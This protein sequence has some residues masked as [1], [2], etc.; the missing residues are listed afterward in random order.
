MSP[1]GL[2]PI[3]PDPHLSSQMLH[4]A[5]VMSA[6]LLAEDPAEGVGQLIARSALMEAS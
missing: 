3:Y 5:L 4:C 2:S 1:E 6:M